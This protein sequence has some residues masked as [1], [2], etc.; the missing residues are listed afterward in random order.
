MLKLDRTE[1]G[2]LDRYADLI[3]TIDSHHPGGTHPAVDQWCWQ[4]ARQH[5]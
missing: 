4:P 1:Y 2:F 3:V 5:D